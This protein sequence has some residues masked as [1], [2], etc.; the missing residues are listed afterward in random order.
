MDFLLRYM[1][2]K[3]VD[4]KGKDILITNGFTEGLDIVLS[5]LGKRSGRVLC[6]NPTHHTAIKNFKL[7]G[8]ELQAS[9]WRMMVLA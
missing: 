5:A 1:Q 9:Q 2:H 4:L 6:E 3:G 7:H 8:F